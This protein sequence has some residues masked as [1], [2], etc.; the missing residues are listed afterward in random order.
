MM[1]KSASHLALL[2]ALLIAGCASETPFLPTIEEQQVLQTV[3]PFDPNAEGINHGETL[4]VSKDDVLK[5]IMMSVSIKGNTALSIA[6]VRQA[7]LANNLMLQVSFFDP[8][9]AKESLKAQQAKFESTFNISASRQ[10]TIIPEFNITSAT[11]MDIETTTTT[12]MPS[13]EIPLTTG[14]TISV[15]DTWSSTASELSIGGASSDSYSDQIT[16]QITQPLL[17][18]E[19]EEYNTASIQLASYQFKIASAQTTLSVINIIQ[20][21]E[22]AY[23]NVYHA[24]HSLLIETQQYHLYE[25]ELKEATELYNTNHSKTLVDIYSFE[26]GL[27]TQAAAVIKADN[28]VRLAIRSLKVLIHEPNLKVGDTIEPYPTTKPDMNRYTF[29]TD[30]LVAMGL[31]HRMELLESEFQLAADALQ[32]KM[33]ENQLLPELDLQA[34]YTWNGFD[35]NNFSGATSD[36]FAGDDKS[37]WQFG[38]TGS[39]A[40]GNEAAKA[41]LRSSILSRLQSIATKEKRRIQVH[42]D[43]HDAIDTLMSTWMTHVATLYELQ[44]TQDKYQSTEQLYKHGQLS[45]T[46]VTQ[47]IMQLGNAKLGLLQSEVNYQLAMV[48]LATATG[49]LMGHSQVEWKMP[50]EQ[51]VSD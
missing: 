45:S 16:A 42:K 26:V 51:I 47:A 8:A 41:N 24:W 12:I 20:S 40:L 11:H 9:I 3:A 10:K 23:W 15:S 32:I 50:E 21:A 35:R 43:V 14:G 36:L 34:G 1:H 4:E 29:D 2:S 49:T 28:R 13:L 25:K 22:L 30:H 44:A 46:D 37:G 18:N 17:K 27:A 48:Q 31:D 7:A 19:G 39:F 33:D 5:T 38:I 6:D